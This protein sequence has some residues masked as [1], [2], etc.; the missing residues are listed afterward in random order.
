ML[1]SAL[2]EHLAQYKATPESATKLL[3]VG[4]SPRHAEIDS[5]ELAAYTT[6]ARILLNLSEFVTKG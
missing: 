6:V 3:S 5:A 4:Q 1:K 2:D